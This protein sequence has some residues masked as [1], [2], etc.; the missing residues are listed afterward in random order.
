MTFRAKINAG[1][2]KDSIESI[3]RLVDEIKLNISEGGVSSKSADP[4]NVAM[5]VFQLGKDGFNEFEIDQEMTIGIDLNRLEDI[6]G[7]ASSSD[8][9]FMESEDGSQ[10]SI[11]VSGFDYNISLLDPSTI[12][13]EP[14]V[15]D[16]DLPAEIVL[17]GNKIRRAVRASEKVS[18]YVVLSTDDDKLLITAKGD[19]DSVKMELGPEELIDIKTKEDVRS[20]FSLDYLADM[21]KSIKKASETKIRLGTDYPVK[22]NFKIVNDKGEIEYLLAP[23]I[24]SE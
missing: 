18:D 22:I 12:Q 6:L 14:K 21:S 16:L 20:I 8:E 13:Q 19:S 15:P 2:F 24:E 1:S 5:V 17:E 9:I 10:L 23:R 4:A 7:V 3:S 11:S